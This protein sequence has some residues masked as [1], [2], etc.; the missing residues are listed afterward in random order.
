MSKPASPSHQNFLAQHGS[1]RQL[2]SESDGGIHVTFNNTSGNQM[3]SISNLQ[4][5]SVEI[6]EGP[7]TSIEVEQPLLKRSNL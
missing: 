6:H 3:A 7:E 2:H 4:R 5:T 1:N